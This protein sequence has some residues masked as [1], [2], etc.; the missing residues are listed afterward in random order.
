ME[1][2]GLVL[3]LS[4]LATRKVSF[5]LAI[6]C[7]KNICFTLG[8]NSLIPQ[9]ETR[10]R[11]DSW[12]LY[13]FFFLP[14]WFPSKQV[15]SWNR[16]LLLKTT[17]G[18]QS[19]RMTPLTTPECTLH[20]HCKQHRFGLPAGDLEEIWHVPGPFRYLQTLRVHH[21]WPRPFLH[22]RQERMWAGESF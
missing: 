20:Q 13:C 21:I 18:F 6:T 8:F 9:A 3:V 22:G 7:L 2:L 16:F 19:L 14:L 12:R 4:I 15:S 11:G 17:Q 1:G 10:S 5:Y